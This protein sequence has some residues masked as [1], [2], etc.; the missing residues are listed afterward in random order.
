M[1]IHLGIN[2]IHSKELLQIP[3]QGNTAPKTFLM[4]LEFQM[5]QQVKSIFMVTPNGQTQY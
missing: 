2:K 3:S 1:A 4:D 5:L